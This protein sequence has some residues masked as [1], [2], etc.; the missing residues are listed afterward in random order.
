MDCAKSIAW[1][2]VICFLVMGSLFIGLAIG[3]E[4]EFNQGFFDSECKVNATFVV[5]KICSTYTCFTGFAVVDVLRVNVNGFPMQVYPP[6][7]SGSQQTMEMQLQ[8]QY[9][10]GSIIACH[11]KIIPFTVVLQLKSHAGLSI[12]GFVFLGIGIAS[13]IA[14][15]IYEICKCCT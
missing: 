4:N 2:L 15:T 14:L 5:E 1:L 12:A 3:T 9:P 10:S 13:L 11:Y 8:L 7:T 6:T